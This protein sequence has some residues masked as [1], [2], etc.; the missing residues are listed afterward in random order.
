MKYKIVVTT[1][2]TTTVEAP[3]QEIAEVFARRFEDEVDAKTG[4]T[5]PVDGCCR[6]VALKGLDEPE[7]RI[8]D[9]G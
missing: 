3:S 8:L 1:V 4:R 9:V 2:E 7:G 6:R 5:L